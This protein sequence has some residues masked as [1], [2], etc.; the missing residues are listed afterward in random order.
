MPVKN[1]DKDPEKVQNVA[2]NFAE[3]FSQPTLSRAVAMKAIK[4]IENDY[5]LRDEILDL[6]KKGA[7]DYGS[8]VYGALLSANDILVANKRFPDNTSLYRYRVPENIV[9]AIKQK[10][11]EADELVPEEE[12]RSS[13]ESKPSARQ[14]KIKETMLGTVESEG[15]ELDDVHK[16]P[17]D[18]EEPLPPEDELDEALNN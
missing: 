12:K 10:I 13:K 15:E 17:A 8:E 7:V 14:K 2:V 9:E 1:L 4:L 11:K 6:Q 16:E 18:E 3:L 5:D